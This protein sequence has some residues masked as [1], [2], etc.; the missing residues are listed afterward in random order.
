MA[1][2]CIIV[3]GLHCE[4]YYGMIMFKVRSSGGTVTEAKPKTMG[5]SDTVKNQNCSFP[6]VLN[7]RFSKINDHSHL[8]HR[9]PSTDVDIHLRSSTES[10][11]A[12]LC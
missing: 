4:I 3:M 8:A 6:V 12:A 10:L 2:V 9:R 7:G 5:F 11:T 1:N